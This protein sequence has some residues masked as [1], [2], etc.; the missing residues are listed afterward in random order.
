MIYYPYE[1][2]FAL[3]LDKTARCLAFAAHLAASLTV[4]LPLTAGGTLA[5]V[6]LCRE[7]FC[8]AAADQRN[9]IRFMFDTPSVAWIAALFVTVALFVLMRFAF[10]LLRSWIFPRDAILVPSGR[11]SSALKGV[12][13]GLAAFLLLQLFVCPVFL[14][15]AFLLASHY[16]LIILAGCAVAGALVGARHPLAREPKRRAWILS[17][18]LTFLP[19]YAPVFVASLVLSLPHALIKKDVHYSSR[20]LCDLALGTRTVN[21]MLPKGATNISVDSRQ[22]IIF[23]RMEWTCTVGEA[24]FLAFAK[25]ND[26]ELAENDSGF[27][28]NPETNHERVECHTLLKLP[29]Y[30]L[31]E[32]YYFYNYRYRNFGGWTILYDRTNHIL[33]GSYSSN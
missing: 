11:V 2:D 7:I 21:K 30:N 23:S 3:R 22:Y 26:Y 32:S 13:F 20:V 9:L 14:P 19:I 17:A 4:L 1:T 28:A 8:D 31:P 33:Y 5:L 10:N 27:N 29:K 12:G 25:E 18:L 15:S 24:D 6:R 16:G